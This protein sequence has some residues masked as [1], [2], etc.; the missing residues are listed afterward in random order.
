[1]INA[2]PA[3]QEVAAWLICD[4]A[5]QRRYPF[6]MSKP[7][8]IPTWPYVR[9]GYLK[10]GKTLADLAALCGIDPTGLQRTVE[11]FNRHARV[12]QDPEFERGTTAFNRAS[13]DPEHLPNPSLA[14]LEKGPYYAI[15][16]RPGSFGTFFG[17]RADARSRALNAAGE[18]IPGLYVAGSDQANVMGGHYP[19]GGINIG[20]AMTFGYIAGRDAA[21]VRAYE[22]VVPA[23]RRMGC[24][25]R[26]AAR[27]ATPAR[28]PVGRA[29][30]PA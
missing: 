23:R 24:D 16:V 18:P 11:D 10:R 8:P 1:M 5:F 25:R 9:S 22:N 2:V 13:G 14:P 27:V 28:N 19:S 7:F 26:T 17:L 12:G 6:G 20:P 21:G 15:K 30:T 4:H 3:G 29:S